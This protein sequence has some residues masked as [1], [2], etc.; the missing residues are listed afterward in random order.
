MNL[1]SPFNGTRYNTS[2]VKPAEVT[3]PP[4][5]V[6]SVEQRD[7]FYEKDQH[8]VIRLELNRDSDPYSSA[9]NFFH[10]WK[11]ESIVVRDEAPAFYVYYQTFRTP[12]GTQVTRRGVL[13]L[14]KTSPYS[15]GN[16]LPHEQTLPKAKKD[17]F[18]LLETTKTQFSPIFGLIDDE[19]QIFDHTIDSVTAMTPLA[20]ID[21]ALPNGEE[22]RH[23]MWKLTD[24]PLVARLEK[25]ISTKKVVIADGHHRYETAVTFGEAHPE[26]PGADEIMIYLANLRGDGT[27][28]LPTHRIL[29]GLTAFNQYS[30][31]TE[32]E[33]K[34]EVTI[35][36][37]REEAMAMLQQSDALT[38][39][40]FT[41]APNWVV[42]KD[43]SD[44][45][46]HPTNLSRLA[47]YRLHEEILKPVAGVTQEQIDAKSNLLYPHTLSELDEMISRQDYNAA[48]I[49]K[50]VSADEMMAITGEGAFMPQKSTY[51]YPKLLS[52]LVFY[53]M[54]ASDTSNAKP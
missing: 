10:A 20:D 13:G 52:G 33:K 15:E 54:D 46:A 31:L 26:I 36:A 53:E 2:K 48:F 1:F 5:D 17:R 35:A 3:S 41:E 50:P 12:E 42:V 51:F 4:Y 40:Q 7:A 8:N 18:A 37:S 32:L 45:T 49:L 9:K 21:E 25:L 6:I 23:T 28:I 11:A 24:P 29:Y 47:V 27:V 44:P 19:A 14:L 43:Q 22:V 30:F 34:F 16:V 39:I 38:A